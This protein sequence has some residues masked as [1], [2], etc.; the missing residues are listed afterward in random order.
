MIRWVDSATSDDDDKLRAW[1]RR[2]F[3]WSRPL[4]STPAL[5]V[6]LPTETVHPG[7]CIP[8]PRLRL[9][10]LG[11][12]RYH[13]RACRNIYITKSLKSVTYRQTYKHNSPLLKLECTYTLWYF[14]ST[15][16]DSG[17]WFDKGREESWYDSS[18]R[19]MLLAL[20]ISRVLTD[21]LRNVFVFVIA[22]CKCDMINLIWS[23]RIFYRTH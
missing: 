3:T 2:S 7:R 17:T 19:R 15:T 1:F 13:W 22:R 12:C 4:T 8:P 5:V 18:G 11:I 10:H 9:M 20:L 6:L 23:H 14:I 21:R 16:P